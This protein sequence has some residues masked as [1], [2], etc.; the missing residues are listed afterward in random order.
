MACVLFAINAGHLRCMRQGYEIQTMALDSYLI[1]LFSSLYEICIKGVTIARRLLGLALIRWRKGNRAV[2]RVRAP[3][4]RR[5]PP[6]PR[7]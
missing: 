7:A 6:L 1:L 4:T 5:P 3:A 2:L